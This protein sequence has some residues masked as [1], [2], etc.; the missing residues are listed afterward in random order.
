M[1]MPLNTPL[2]RVR[3]GLV[4]LLSVVVLATLGYHW[5]AG[6]SLV[7]SLW[8]VVVTISTVGFSER[9]VL[10]DGM[11][12]F[13][14]G[15][16]LVGILAGSYTFSGLLHLMVE[17][18]IQAALGRR[19]MTRE[20]QR[21]NNHV[22]ICGYGRIGRQLAEGLDD[23]QVEFV[24]VDSSTD[25]FADA[26]AT[27]RLFILGDATEESVL[28]EAGL[29]SADYL[30]SSLPSDADNV[31]ITLTARNLNS[32][33]EIICRAEQA[34]TEA[35]LLQAGA[36][37]V[38][39]PTIISARH[40]IRMITRPSTYDLMELVTES[41]F[42]DVELDEMHVNAGNRLRGVTVA[43][44]EAHRR[45]RLLVVA[46]KQTN[47]DMIFNPDAG[48]QFAD[49]DTLIMMGRDQDIEKFRKFYAVVE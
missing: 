7:D 29:E 33:A 48:Y 4:V 11:Q 15:V 5:G 24:I 16:I 47:G 8:L 20:I 45:H 9:S 6:F 10:S 41:K 14:V 26:Q 12:L 32:K 37:R 18:E 23:A 3:I 42:L 13:T 38:L 31:F 2:N 19:R 43:E 30:M 35:K 36:S 49:G 22:I 21:L 40:M 28:L 17:G 39:L 27:D 25:N 44:S 34:S 46:I 1:V